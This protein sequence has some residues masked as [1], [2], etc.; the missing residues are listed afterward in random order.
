[1]FTKRNG[2][3]NTILVVSV[4][5]MLIG[6]CTPKAQQGTPLAT[7]EVKTTT[8]TEVLQ[9]TETTVAE[10]L[11]PGLYKIGFSATTSGTMSF[12]GVPLSNGVNLAVKE[13]NETLF[14]GKGATIG[15]W[16]QDDGADPAT[17]INITN[18]FVADNNVLGVVCCVSSNV[19]LAMKPLLMDNKVPTIIY[20]AIR[21]DLVDGD[22]MFRSSDLNSERE[23][24][25][26]KTIMTKGGYKYVV[27][28]DT[29]D[30]DGQVSILAVKKAVLDSMGIKYDVVDTLST[31]TDFRGAATQIISL[32]PDAVMIVQTGEAGALTVKALRELGYAGFID[33]NDVLSNADLYKIA[34]NALAGI[35]MPV[36]FSPVSTSEAAQKFIKLYE[37]EYNGQTPDIYAAQGYQAMWM[38]AMGLKAGGEGTRE[39]LLAGLKSLTSIPTPG[40]TFSIDSN[41]QAHATDINFIQWN[42]DGVLIPW[43]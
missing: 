3:I 25:A 36:T 19:T 14:L 22:Y 43:P 1:M 34:G 20:A 12:A 18:Q 10:G 4:I 15:V 11:A 7:T 27:L 32:K 23:Q 8:E 28:V 16:E 41:G 39:A 30:N 9:P 6:A 42:S 5:A 17:A 35:P 29:S 24:I 26:T 31:D 38:M 37:A 21:L 33:G 40:G 13:I 2:W